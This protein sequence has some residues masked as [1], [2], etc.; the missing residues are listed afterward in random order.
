MKLYE[1]EMGDYSLRLLK[2]NTET[3]DLESL[4]IYYY[5]R[6]IELHA[7]SCTPLKPEEYEIK[8]EYY[9]NLPVDT[10]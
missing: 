10:W 1:I 4:D 2:T 6:G 8:K 3:L 7:Y 5:N 9:K